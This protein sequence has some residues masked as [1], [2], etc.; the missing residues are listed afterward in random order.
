MA[1]N[2]THARRLTRPPQRFLP[3]PTPSAQRLFRRRPAGY[4]RKNRPGLETNQPEHLLRSIWTDA[5]RGDRAT[6]KPAAAAV[7]MRPATAPVGRNQARSNQ[8]G[9]TGWRS[10]GV[11]VA[12]GL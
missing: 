8:G 5:R 4:P 9:L 1:A 12:A 3:V 10:L 2:R 6:K 7:R 11:A